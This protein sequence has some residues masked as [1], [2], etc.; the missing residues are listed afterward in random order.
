M[1]L[2]VQNAKTA[3]GKEIKYAFAA[4][5]AVKDDGHSEME[6][7]FSAVPRLKVQKTR[8]LLQGGGE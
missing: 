4:C 1:L 7:G 5:L 6:R 2:F 8:C 3:C